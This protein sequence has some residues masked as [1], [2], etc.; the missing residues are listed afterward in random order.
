MILVM[1]SL[2]W[3]ITY[4]ICILHNIKENATSISDITEMLQ[5]HRELEV[6]IANMEEE[7][8]SPKQMCS[9]LQ[10]ENEELQNR[11]TELEG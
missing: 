6:S 2:Y 1:L 8:S 5:G 9:L 7:M 3:L 10:K 11:T 4:T